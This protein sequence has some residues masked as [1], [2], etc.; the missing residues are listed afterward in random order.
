[1]RAGRELTGVNNSDGA[2]S[3]DGQLQSIRT[4]SPCPPL[5]RGLPSTVHSSKQQDAAGSDTS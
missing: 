1:M 4:G 5:A 3:A 2:T